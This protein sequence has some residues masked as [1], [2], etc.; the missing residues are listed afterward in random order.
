MENPTLGKKKSKTGTAEAQRSTVTFLRLQK[1][2]KSWREKRLTKLVY[3]LFIILFLDYNTQNPIL[4][5]KHPSINRSD[6]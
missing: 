4:V 2:L 6:S 5:A 3:S 1:T